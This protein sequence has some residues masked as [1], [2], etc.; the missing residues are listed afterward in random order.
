MFEYICCAY[1]F[2]GCCDGLVKIMALLI[3]YVSYT[4]ECYDVF[5]LFIGVVYALVNGYLLLQTN[6]LA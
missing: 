6:N 4:F 2:T 3:H 5:D 1:K